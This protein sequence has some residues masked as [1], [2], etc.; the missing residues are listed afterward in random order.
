MPGFTEHSI[1]SLFA[2]DAKSFWKIDNIE[3]W[4]SSLKV[5]F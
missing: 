4:K 5:K 2:D 3:D 1:L